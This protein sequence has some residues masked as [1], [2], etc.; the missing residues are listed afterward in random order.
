MACSLC[1]SRAL[2]EF[3]EGSERSYLECGQCSLIQVPANYHISA[4]Q[5][6]QHYDTHENNPSDPNYRKFLDRLA[7][8]LNALLS[9][10]SKG[11]DFGSGPGPTLSLMMRERGHQV[12]DYDL[13]YAPDRDALQQSYDFIT[14]TEVV[15]H[16][17]EPGVVLTQLWGLLNSGG[18]MAVMTQM[19]DAI[20]DFAD[21]YYQRD[22]THIC[23]WSKTTFR[24]LGSRLHCSGLSFPDASVCLLQR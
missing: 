8:P 16:L 21:W 1:Q 12:R 20:D 19:T 7:A 11:L 5:E 13:Y 17:K 15:E 9:P 23:F 18:V 4:E 3:C 10:A 6:K 14:L 24:W 22:P 2:K